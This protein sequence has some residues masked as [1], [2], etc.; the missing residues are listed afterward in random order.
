[1]A[2]QRL[3][4]ASLGWHGIEGDRRLA[5]RRIQ[6]RTGFPWL[7]AS[8]LAD[9]LRFTPVPAEGADDG[10]PTHVRSPEGEVMDVFGDQLR[11]EIGRRHGA[12]VEVMHIRGGVFDD[13]PVSVI[14]ASTIAEISRVAAMEPDNRRF[15][16]NIVVRLAD[17]RPFAEDEWVG[18]FLEFGDDGIGPRIGVTMR[19]VRCSMINLDP[20]TAR[21]APEMLKAAVRAN[22]NNAGIYGTVVRAGRL[23]VGQRIRFQ[24]G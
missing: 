14:T 4:S 21:S 2:G 22:G 12:P 10:I 9:L 17:P 15:R 13:G 23:T 19:D 6:D 5:V 3:E 18:G 24:A 1:M 20:E 7:S 16:P 8:R 11:S